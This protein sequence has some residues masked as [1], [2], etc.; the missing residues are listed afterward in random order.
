MRF[1]IVMKRTNLLISFQVE[2]ST[3]TDLVKQLYLDVQ[4]RGPKAFRELIGTLL[5]SGNYEAA[6]ILVSY[7][8]H[9]IFFVNY[10][11]AQ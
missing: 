8:Q 2:H 7:S 10:A 6:K 5:G 9:F 11:S 1:F 4:R 3:L